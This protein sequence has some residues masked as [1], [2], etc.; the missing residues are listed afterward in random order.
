MLSEKQGWRINM[1]NDFNF[2][3]VC[4]NSLS[5]KE[6]EFDLHFFLCNIHSFKIAYKDHSSIAIGILSFKSFCLSNSHTCTLNFVWRENF[7]LPLQG[8]SLVE[9]TKVKWHP[10]FPGY[11][12][13][14]SVWCESPHCVPSKTKHLF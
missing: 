14:V 10:I 12:S 3:K 1:L 11:L 2:I 5:L 6:V 9:G 8:Q 7:I 4:H 13:K